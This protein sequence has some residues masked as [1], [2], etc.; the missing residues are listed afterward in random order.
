MLISVGLGSPGGSVNIKKV[1]SR[2]KGKGKCM[3]VYIC[4]TVLEEL[5]SAKKVL[6][7]VQGLFIIL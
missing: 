5:R 7:I 4:R 3:G 2:E 6:K 1:R